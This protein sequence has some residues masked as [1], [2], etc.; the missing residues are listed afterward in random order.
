MNNKDSFTTHDLA[1]SLHQ[2]ASLLEH[3]ERTDFR[4]QFK[5]TAYLFGE[6]PTSLIHK[7]LDIFD[8]FT[9]QL[10]PPKMAAFEKEIGA[11]II[12]LVTMSP[13]VVQEEEALRPTKVA[14][15]APA[16][17]EKVR[18]ATKPPIG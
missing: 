12:R 2:I 4:T 8:G 14:A 1:A 17:R 9:Y 10:E 5:L 11:V 13:E 7:F 18:E 16:F 15:L 3:S 6:N